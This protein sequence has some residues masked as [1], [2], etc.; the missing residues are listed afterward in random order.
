MTLRAVFFGTPDFA[1]PSFSALLD[2]GVEVPLVVTQPD[3]PV[4]RHAAPRPSAVADAAAAR[5]IALAKPERLRGNAEMLAQ[6]SQ[7]APDVGIVVAY[8]KLLPTALLEVPR[9]AF[10]NVHASLLP[11]Y[12]GA[13]PIQA[14]IL[15]GDRET[16]IVTMRVVEE[17]DAG[18]IYI[19]RRVAIGERERADSLSA[20]LAAAGGALLV[21]T[22]RGFEAGSISAAPQRGEPSFCRPVR[23]EDGEVDWALPAVA[24]ERHLR[25]YTPWP[26]L[27]TFLGDERVKILAAETGPGGRPEAPG[28][29]WTENGRLFAAAGGG[30]S[31]ELGQLQRA[32]RRPVSG[33]DF[34][35]AVRPPRRFGRPPS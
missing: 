30:S 33:P 11:K 2:S 12:R 26:G 14:A 16:G 34:A 35:L 24:I 8:G 29:L 4:G 6:V 21:E 27:Y 1:V 22:L 18:P 17:L 28:V 7:A 3:R 20:R 13:S 9:L 25:A 15:A 23:R 32:G 5:G 31:I 19:E 10:V